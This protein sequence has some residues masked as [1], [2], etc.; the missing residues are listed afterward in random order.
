[1]VYWVLPNLERFNVRTEV[2]HGLALPADY[3][4]FATGYGLLY[5]AVVLAIA[6]LTF[7]FREF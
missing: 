1:V 3:L 2:V 5:A 6:A 4:G 7:H